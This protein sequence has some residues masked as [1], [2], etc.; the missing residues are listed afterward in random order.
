M[1]ASP[2]VRHKKLTKANKANSNDY[3]VRFLWYST[4]FPSPNSLRH[5]TRQFLEREREREIPLLSPAPKYLIK[6]E[7]RPNF[8]AN[9]M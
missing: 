3:L 9:R 5:A 1:Y 6:G 8:E 7:Q 4:Y 2:I